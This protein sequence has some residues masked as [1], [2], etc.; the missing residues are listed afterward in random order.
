M[1][2]PRANARG[3]PFLVRRAAVA[4]G[5]SPSAHDYKTCPATYNYSR[6]GI[7]KIRP[8]SPAGGVNARSVRGQRRFRPKGPKVNSQGREPLDW[9]P[10]ARRLNS[11]G[12]TGARR[13]GRTFD[14]MPC[15]G[16]SSVA[17]AGLF[18]MCASVS[19][20]S[21]PWLLTS[22]PAG[23]LAR[24]AKKLA[25]LPQSVLGSDRPAGENLEEI[26]H[27]EKTRRPF[28]PRARRNRPAMAP[29]HC[30]DVP[31]AGDFHG[32]RHRGPRPI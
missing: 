22:A 17:P 31:V 13:T 4:W 7:W 14:E 15:A 16:F 20:G 5:G 26:S 19:R 6:G 18:R 24:T 21:R 32:P 3:P 1:Q 11:D 27:C 8:V 10:P 2:H 25:T 28:T 23:L 9:R 29:Q 30:D 12:V